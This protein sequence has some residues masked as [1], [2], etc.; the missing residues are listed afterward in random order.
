MGIG[1]ACTSDSTCGDGGTCLL[2]TGQGFLGGGPV[3][4]LCVKDCKASA[5]LCGA[6]TKCVPFGSDKYCVESCEYGNPQLPE[7]PVVDVPEDKCHGRLD[8][9]C[10]PLGTST[11]GVC[12]PRCWP[13]QDGVDADRLCPSGTAC[14]PIKGV[15]VT[16]LP[17]NLLPTGAACSPSSKT[18]QCVGDCLALDDQSKTG[19][20]SEPCTGAV[21]ESCG[22]LDEG[23]C[24]LDTSSVTKNGAFV[25]FGP[26]DVA[27][28]A[29]ATTSPTADESCL[30]ESGWF[31][32]S[33]TFPGDVVRSFCLPAAEC[34]TTADC[35]E[36]CKVKEDC[37]HT[38]AACVSGQCT[39]TD[40]CQAV[41]GRKYCMDHTPTVP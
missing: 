20:C 39:V 32:V 7:T 40:T 27:G 10:S 22:G 25:L 19:I 15:C 4:G 16:D 21:P 33:F 29:K 13:D 18:R 34:K 41:E 9:S 3:Q 8:L 14:D 35:S 23:I 31:P 1:T 38:D 12:V 17:A 2:P 37:S 11:S 24:F 28:C 26:L 5:L 6:G 30:W 36:S